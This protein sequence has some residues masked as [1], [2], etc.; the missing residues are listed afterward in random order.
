[1]SEVRL[2][3]SISF[4]YG[5]FLYPEACTLPVDFDCSEVGFVPCSMLTLGH[6]TGQVTRVLHGVYQTGNR[7]VRAIHTTIASK[8]LC[9]EPAARNMPIAQAI[10]NRVIIAWR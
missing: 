7:K 2:L 8:T 10:R 1:M 4:A 3:S 5:Y 9:L 6:T